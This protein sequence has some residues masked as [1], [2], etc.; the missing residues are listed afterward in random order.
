MIRRITVTALTAILLTASATAQDAKA[1]LTSASQAMGTQNLTSVTYSGT[2]SDVNFLQTKSIQGP[3]PLRPITGYTR[4][5]DLAQLAMRSTGQTNN[6][7]LFGGAP[8]TGTYTQNIPATA[9]TW[10]QQLEYWITPWG[11][12]KGATAN[13]ATVRAQRINGRNYI[14]VTWSPAGLKAPSGIAYT[15]NGYVSDQN[16]V[17]RVETW[18]EHDILGDM[19]IETLYGEYKNFGGL[20]VPTRIIQKR[21]GWPYFETEVTAASANPS[22]LA[23]LLGG[24]G[25][26]GGGGR[27]GGA[28]AP[29]AP[30]GAPAGDG[31]G[32]QQTAPGA[33]PPVRQPQEPQIR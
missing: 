8:V 26:R 7:P 3:W 31:R 12:L 33:V 6:P 25:G 17:D 4:A 30:A 5:I 23:Q 11:F 18:V 16:L 20:R 10:A 13:K 19:H 21:A 15:V 29:A 24:G 14:V 1:V 2:A 27:G 28:P 9:T 32:V 22:D